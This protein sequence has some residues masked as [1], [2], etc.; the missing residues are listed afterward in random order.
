MPISL[1]F[2]TDKV[3]VSAVGKSFSKKEALL[4]EKGIRTL[5]SVSQKNQCGQGDSN[6]HGCPLPPQSSA[7]TNS[8]MTAD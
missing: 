2:A 3:L 6:S 5:A 4:F 1:E 8:A 7:Y